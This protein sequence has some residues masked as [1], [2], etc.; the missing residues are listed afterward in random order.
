MSTRRPVAPAPEPLEAYIQHFDPLFTKRNQR[1]AFRRYLEGVLLAAER[2][3]TL[4]AIANT[5]PSSARSTAR[6]NACSGFSP[7]RRGRPR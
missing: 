1:H 4:T 7:S 6:L 5:E 3:K 2:T